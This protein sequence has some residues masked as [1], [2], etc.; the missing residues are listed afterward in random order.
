MRNMFPV[1]TRTYKSKDAICTIC[2]TPV[3]LSPSASERAKKYGETA[4]YYIDLFPTHSQCFIE[5][6]NADTSEFIKRINAQPK[7]YVTISM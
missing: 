7:Q 5:K 6:R 3:V 4:Q 2:K 1:A